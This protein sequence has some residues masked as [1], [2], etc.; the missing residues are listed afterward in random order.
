MA[1]DQDVDN[2]YHIETLAFGKHHWSKESILKE[3][4]HSFS[5]Y[6]ICEVINEYFQ[7]SDK[8]IGYSGIWNINDEGHITTMAIDES[9]RGNHIADI[10]L[11]SLII[12]AIHNRVKWLTLEVRSTNQKAINLYKKF[13][14]KQ[15]GLR[16]KYYQ[17]NNE[18]ALILWS[19]DISNN[20][21]IKSL[22]DIISPF[23]YSYCHADK[24]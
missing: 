9:Y 1:S 22:D 4:S 8:L 20:E 17:D 3:L 13:Q 5:R 21:Y 24:L 19:E 14:F 2:M 23:K 11:Y 12:L 15:I 6:I 16:K 7:I 18:D 10:L